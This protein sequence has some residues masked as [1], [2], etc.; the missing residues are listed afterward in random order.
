MGWQPS[1]TPP[2]PPPP[3]PLA[4]E[5]ETS[6]IEIEWIV[7]REEKMIE[8][9]DYEEKFRDS[10]QKFVSTVYKAGEPQVKRLDTVNT[11]GFNIWSFLNE[12]E[13]FDEVR[14]TMATEEDIKEFEEYFESEESDGRKED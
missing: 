1:R 3:K 12:A 6:D 5:F 7:E 11:I 13:H 10:K 2:K 9:I 14:I 8:M 4:I